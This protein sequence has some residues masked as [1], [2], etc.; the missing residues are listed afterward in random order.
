MQVN[1]TMTQLRTELELAKKE[2]LELSADLFDYK[3]LYADALRD[4]V[5]MR[6]EA[7]TLREALQEIADDDLYLRYCA[8]WHDTNK[9]TRGIQAFARKVLERKDEKNKSD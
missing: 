8:E 9:M 2:I 5:R 7:K 6:D 1:H 4:Y 3:T